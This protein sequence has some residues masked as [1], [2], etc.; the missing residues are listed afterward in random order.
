MMLAKNLKKI[1]SKDFLIVLG[2][3]FLPLVWKVLEIALLAEFENA[4]KIL[5]QLT[6]ISIIFKVF[7]ETLLNPLYKTLNKNDFREE[8]EKIYTAKKFFVFYFFA[9]VCF[10]A[11]VFF[12]NKYI[13]EA[14]YVPTY[15][16]DEVFVFFRIYIFAC[17]FGI[18]SKF[19]YT[20]NLISK[21]TKKCF[22]IC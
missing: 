20:F 17:G 10:T 9:T 14:S 16:F 4:L 3:G 15:I 11:I 13:I 7:E 8:E 6:L 19:L 2:I 22:C 21:N 1:Y 5:G 12:L 18:I